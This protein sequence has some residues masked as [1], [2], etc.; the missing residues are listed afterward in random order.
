MHMPLERKKPALAGLNKERLRDFALSK[1]VT[2]EN[3]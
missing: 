1:P 2:L 3:G